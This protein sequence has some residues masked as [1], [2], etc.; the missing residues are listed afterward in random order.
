MKEKHNVNFTRSTCTWENKI[1]DCNLET[2]RNSCIHITS[3]P[4]CTCINSKSII[5]TIV[6]QIQNQPT[7]S[8]F[9]RSIFK[10]FG[11]P[12]P[13]SKQGQ[14][15]LQNWQQ[16]VLWHHPTGDKKQKMMRVTSLLELKRCHILKILARLITSHLN[17]RFWF[18]LEP[19]IL[20][21]ACVWT[22]CSFRSLS[23][24]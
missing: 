14:N 17:L 8:P 2:H 11:P 5:S 1:T 18:L 15:Q 6:L 19:I 4:L 16:I 12:R 20:G 3:I 7:L 13:T 21:V 10:V 9:V 22:C 23:I 24:G